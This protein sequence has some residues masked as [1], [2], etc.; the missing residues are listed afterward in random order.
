MAAK[1]KISNI[2]IGDSCTFKVKSECGAPVFKVNNVKNLHLNTSID[3]TW[4]E[5]NAKKIKKGKGMSD[6]PD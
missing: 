3:V 5:W 2:S 4:I 1:I 6:K